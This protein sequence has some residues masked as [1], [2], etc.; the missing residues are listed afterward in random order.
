MRLQEWTG[1]EQGRYLQSC[2]RSIFTGSGALLLKWWNLFNLTLYG[3]K[4]P[5]F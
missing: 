5:L 2:L 4:A 3:A 1:K